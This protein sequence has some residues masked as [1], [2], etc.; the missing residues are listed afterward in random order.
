[1]GPPVPGADRW[2][3]GLR[4]SRRQFGRWT[5]GGWIAAA[6]GGL[7]LLVAADILI[8]TPS[9]QEIR[10]LAE[11]PRA[12]TIYDL[13]GQPAFTIFKERRIEVPLD[14][15]SPN[16]VKA[17][18]AIED[19]RFYQHR[20]ID[21]W[22]IGGAL[23]ANFTS[24]DGLQGGSTITQQLARKTFLTDERTIRRKLKEVYLALRIERQFTKDQIL[25]AYL[26]R[27]Y[28][29]GGFYGIEAAARGYFNK[30]AKDLRVDEA[31]LLAGVIQAPSAY[32]PT[33]H[34]ERAVARRAVV[35]SQMVDAGYLDAAAAGK[36]KDAPVR[37]EAGFGH[38]RFGQYFKNAITRQL[39]A[40]FGWELV[41]QGG[42]RVYATIDPAMQRAAE[43]ALA[44]GIADAEKLT[45][46]R[47]PRTR[48]TASNVS[49]PLQGALVAIDPLNG[50]VRALV[51]GRNFDESQ[52]DR[53]TQARRQAGSAFKPFVYATALEMGATPATLL[54]DLDEPMRTA[55][56]M[57]VPED[58]HL[59]SE[60][61]TVRTALRTSSNRAAVQVL[62]RV[63]IPR[64]V[65]GA[66]RFGLVAPAVPSLVL[67]AGEVTLL[68]LTAA[69]GVFANGGWAREPVLIR[70]V[71]DASG[72]V[73]F[74]SRARET[75]ALSEEASFLMAQM[76]ADV[77][78]RGT[79]SQVRQVG[80]H[81]PAAG[82]TGTTNDYHDAW[83]IG[84]TP[85]LVAGVWVG[86]DQ[87]RPIMPSGYAGEISAP[88]WGRFMREAVGNRSGG[89]V[90]RPTSV[91]AVEICRLSGARPNSGC[92]RVPTVSSDG[93]V[94]AKSFVGIEYFRTG[95]QPDHVCDIHRPLSFLDRIRGLVGASA[96]TTPLAEGTAIGVLPPPPAARVAERAGETRPVADRGVPSEVDPPTE[97]KK[98]FWSRLAGVF[99]GGG[100]EKKD[101]KKDD[102]KDVKK[103]R[104]SG[105]GDW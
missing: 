34:L 62:R 25:E 77:V 92:L 22:R 50:E 17:V 31:A 8:A 82:K 29:G 6:F 80:F 105:G 41:S 78:D 104:G 73:L 32:A 18:V 36:L 89:W 65:S 98:G 102:K 44:R 28:F 60:T 2:P 99:T 69:Y 12:T 97:K 4:W 30:P 19:Q 67:G 54:T 76:L 24:S 46:R 38:E 63:G 94:T 84:F 52:F 75:R 48:S 81:Q 101:E 7:W 27:V 74:Q 9:A 93:T 90:R 53:A 42:L 88:I 85:S 87:P 5:L 64:A 33:A 49:D 39:V 66:G 58:E 100:G 35:L 23:V 51:G 55:E 43:A 10:G 11:M 68:S 72:T 83:F 21:V 20:G 16:V 26:N 59:E 47:S 96:S 79:G 86:F 14:A 95:T 61:M 91:V 56:G 40:E 45:A 1:V 37:L 3:R 71:E 70:R 13:A 57:W 15:I 103:P